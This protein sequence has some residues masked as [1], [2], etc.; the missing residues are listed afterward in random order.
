M[1][2]RLSAAIK[3]YDIN[4]FKAILDQDSALYNEE[5]ILGETATVKI[6]T[7]RHK[8]LYVISLYFKDTIINKIEILFNNKKLWFCQ[9]DIYIM[10][11]YLELW[12]LA[13]KFHPHNISETVSETQQSNSCVENSCITAWIILLSTGLMSKE[14][15][16]SIIEHIDVPIPFDA[17]YYAYRYHNK[18]TFELLIK[19]EKSNIPEIGKRLLSLTG[20]MDRS[21]DQ[22]TA[23]SATLIQ[24]LLDDDRVILP[25]IIPALIGFPAEITISLLKNNQKIIPH[26]DY[27]FIAC[28]KW[29]SY[30]LLSRLFEDYDLSPNVV[31]QAL[32][33]AVSCGNVAAV[34]VILQHPAVNISHSNFEILRNYS[35]RYHW[36][37]LY[38]VCSRAA[39][40]NQINEALAVLIGKHSLN[41]LSFNADY[42]KQ[43]LL[44]ATDWHPEDASS[45]WQ[46][47]GTLFFEL[48]RI[49]NLRWNHSNNL[50]TRACLW[51]QL[52]LVKLALPFA[53]PA[54]F[55]NIALQAA[56]CKIPEQSFNKDIYNLLTADVNVLITQM[57]TFHR[58]GKSFIGDK[59]RANINNNL[60]KILYLRRKKETVIRC[61]IYKAEL[62]YKSIKFI[63]TQ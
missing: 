61:E 43:I 23:P 35:I 53:N 22:P 16:K 55:N 60:E 32:C 20:W 10:A 57:K 14:H 37:I 62:A 15:F 34:D 24:I 44:L 19:T 39:M 9:H 4:L 25:N 42:I 56:M 28:R 33:I 18:H 1:A 45:D 47:F 27:L 3:A 36:P 7:V 52:N 30:S 41:N 8:F 17:I 21:T 13:T 6:S 59:K 31:H 49:K 38:A 29:N 48:G 12:D 58:F 46:Y 2:L 40:D 26:N 63:K 51:R 11:C 50:L 54:A 5:F